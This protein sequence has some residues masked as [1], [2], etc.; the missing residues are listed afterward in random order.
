[1]T[2]LMRIA[3]R[4]GALLGALAGRWTRVRGPGRDEPAFAVDDSQWRRM[5]LLNLVGTAALRE[6]DEDVLLAEAAREACRLLRASR[7]TI[8][9]FGTP[10]KVVEHVAPE[11]GPTVAAAP[12]TRDAADRSAIVS[13]PLGTR[14]DSIGMLVLEQGDR[15]F[16][17]H[18]EVAAAEATARQIA[19]A[20]RH[21]RL[22]HEQQELAGR[23][24]SLMNN[25]PGLV[26]RGL[27]D[28]STSFVAAEAE[29]IT[30]Y[31]AE[32][33]MKGAVAMRSIVHPA[34]L[35]LLDEK[36]HAAVRAAVGSLRVEYRI[37][38]K[39]G[40]YR[41]LADRRQL[42]Y[43]GGGR[44]LHIDGL[45]LDIARRVWRREEVLARL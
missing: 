32:E 16:R 19:I 29:R 23:L 18:D 30:G 21:V 39:D 22:F 1:M 13:A 40:S 8:R 36:M 2:V 34:D 5:E 33:F 26:Y 9:I 35:A 28:W 14:D 10:D 44:I 43:D 41:W 12:E 15:P 20:V 17:A 3:T 45:A 25:V 27:P 11:N 7:C 4:C 37:R 24:W 38:Q 42:V 6:T 31:S